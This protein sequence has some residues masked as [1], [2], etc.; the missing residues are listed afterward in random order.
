M[1]NSNARSGFLLVALTLL[2]GACAS[3]KQVTRVQTLDPAADAPYS[4]VLVIALLESFD[5]R[6][7][8]EGEIVKQLKSKGITA[9]PSSSLMNTKTP[10]TRDTF[11]AQVKS[12]GSDAVILSQ[13]VNLQTKTNYKDARP[14][15]T[16][17]VWPTYYYNVW[18]VELTEYVAPQMVELDH[19]FT[20][21]T[22]MFSV[23]QLQPVWGI[24][25]STKIKVDQD[26][27]G[28]LAIMV[29]EAKAIVSYLSRDGL[30]KR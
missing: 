10:V 20:L 24:E 4:N 12:Q 7:Y 16:Y 29:D 5:A 15:S 8:F 27:L 19:S 26:H 17:N 22:Q 1:N 30:L 11:L 25:T 6:R 28:D 23:S 13:L 21:A 9:V 2:L 3:S 14:R 18:N